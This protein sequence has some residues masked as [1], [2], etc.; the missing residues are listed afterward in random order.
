MKVIGYQYDSACGCPITKAVLCK[1]DEEYERIA[2]R[3]EAAGYEP[4]W[5]DEVLS[6][7]Q[8]LG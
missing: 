2:E 7:E 3:I 1:T 4:I 5:F 6:A 8:I